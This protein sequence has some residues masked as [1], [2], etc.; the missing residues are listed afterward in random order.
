[1]LKGNKAYCTNKAGSH[2]ILLKVALYSIARTEI[3]KVVV[4]YLHST[5]ANSEQMMCYC[6]KNREFCV[7]AHVSCWLNAISITN[8]IIYLVGVP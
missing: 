6:S 8:Y 1:M 5:T 7:V 3:Q 4:V 2:E